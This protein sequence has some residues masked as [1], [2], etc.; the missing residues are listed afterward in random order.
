LLSASVEDFRRDSD[1]FRDSVGR[2]ETQRLIQTAMKHGRQTSDAEQDL[3]AML[4][5]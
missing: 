1:L 2:A 4:V 3:A 5:S